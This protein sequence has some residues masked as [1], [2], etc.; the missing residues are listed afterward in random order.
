MY[1]CIGVC[2]Q[3]GESAAG[4]PGS[5]QEKAAQ[6]ETGI[7]AVYQTGVIVVYSILA[8]GPGAKLA[9]VPVLSSLRK[10]QIITWLESATS[11]RPS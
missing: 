1:V 5:H 9:D 2:T 8:D 11:E 7:T 4:L 6:H 10:Q 3:G